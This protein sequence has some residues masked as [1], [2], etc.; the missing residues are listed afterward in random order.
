MLGGTV[1][2]AAEAIGVTPSAVTQWPEN[3]PKRISDRVLAVMARRH[4]PPELIGAQSAPE[5][6]LPTK[7]VG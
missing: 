5:A 2:S 4:L 3:L 1:G 7:T 6:A